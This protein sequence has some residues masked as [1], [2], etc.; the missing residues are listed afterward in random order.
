L[1]LVNT[2]R[3]KKRAFTGLPFILDNPAP[4]I[5]LYIL[6]FT[7]G[8]PSRLARAHFTATSE[9]H[10]RITS[11]RTLDDTEFAAILRAG[12]AT[13]EAI[14]NQIGTTGTILLSQEKAKKRCQEP[15]PWPTALWAA[16]MPPWD[17]PCES[18]PGDWFTMS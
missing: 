7:L 4:H 18:M 10:M 16:R 15:F 12:G 1:P 13:W 11:K 14:T 9:A 5:P 6:V 2:L 8:R 3:P 17:A